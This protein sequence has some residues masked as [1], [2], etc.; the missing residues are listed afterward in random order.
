MYL[1]SSGEKANVSG[2]IRHN[3]RVQPREKG[4]NRI[5]PSI[6]FTVRYLTQHSKRVFPLFFYL[7]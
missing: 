2:S 1:F 5:I 7:F 3:K 6:D 4:T